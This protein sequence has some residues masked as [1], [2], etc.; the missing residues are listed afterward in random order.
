M[1]NRELFQHGGGSPQRRGGNRE[2]RPWPVQKQAQ[3]C[4]QPRS[5]FL[6]VE[7]V[8]AQEHHRH[9]D[10]LAQTGGF[11]Q[12]WP[13]EEQGEGGIEGEQGTRPSRRQPA[14]EREWKA[15]WRPN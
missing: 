12:R 11:T 2:K 10:G 9:A 4:E 8:G 13:G 15:R 3:R 5:R 7:E 14:Q 1:I 6:D